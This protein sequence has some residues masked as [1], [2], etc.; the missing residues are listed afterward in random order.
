MDNFVFPILH[1]ETKLINAQY[2]EFV[3]VVR[4]VT[5]QNENGIP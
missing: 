5:S 3:L 1:S 4:I 2:I